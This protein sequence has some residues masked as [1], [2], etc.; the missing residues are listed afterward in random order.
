MLVISKLFNRKKSQKS[1]QQIKVDKSKCENP[2]KSGPASVIGKNSVV[3]QAE[4]SISEVQDS[5]QFVV[6]LVSLQSFD[7]SFN[8]DNDLCTILDKN[9]NDLQRGI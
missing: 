7:G 6:R 9:L 2:A 1:P 4:S 8:L 5:S 3:T